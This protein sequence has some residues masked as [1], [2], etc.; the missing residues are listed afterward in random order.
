M[1]A[2]V[3]AQVTPHMIPTVLCAP[4]LQF[5]K[6]NSYQLAITITQG[7]NDVRCFDRTLQNLSS[8]IRLEIA[9]IITKTDQNS[10]GLMPKC[11]QFRR[12]A[13]RFSLIIFLWFANFLKMPFILFYPL[14][15]NVSLNIDCAWQKE[16]KENYA[17][18]WSSLGHTNQSLHCRQDIVKLKVATLYMEI[19]CS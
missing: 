18:L 1:R 11:I 7:L 5:Y 19:S 8:A 14:L 3:I 4:S 16:L 10:C 17:L 2:Y 12:I 9:I 15:G 6:E 13:I